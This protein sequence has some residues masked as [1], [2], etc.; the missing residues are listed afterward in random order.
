MNVIKASNSALT[1]ALGNATEV[2]S[3][4]TSVISTGLAAAEAGAKQLRTY[5]EIKEQEAVGR[6]RY[7]AELSA[8]SVINW[9]YSEHNALTEELVQNESERNA[10]IAKAAALNIQVPEMGINA[11][12]IQQLTKEFN[13]MRKKKS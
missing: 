13:A 9:Y 3:V 11:D 10:I 12:S 1:K 2:V 6:A 8:L 5:A 4:A 7:S